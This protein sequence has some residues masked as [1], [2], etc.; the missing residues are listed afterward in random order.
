METYINE[1]QVN[2]VYELVRDYVEHNIRKYFEYGKNLNTE[3]IDVFENEIF[4]IPI[5]NTFV[6]CDC[7]HDYVVKS[8]DYPNEDAFLMMLDR[9]LTYKKEN[10]EKSGYEM[11]MNLLKNKKL[12]MNYY[13]YVVYL[14]EIQS[15]MENLM[16]E[17]KD[18]LNEDED[19]D[20]IIIIKKKLTEKNTIF[21]IHII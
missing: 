9:I 11:I 14:E 21:C 10:G 3:T 16:K 15:D 6:K 17:I 5:N 1:N 7:F 4:I 20:E 19:E 8:I 18:E 12:I 13:A 2:C